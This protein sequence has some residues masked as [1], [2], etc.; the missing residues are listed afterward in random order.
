VRFIVD[1]HPVEERVEGTVALDGPGEPSPFSGWLE[2]LRLLETHVA[3][4]PVLP[5]PVARRAVR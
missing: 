3:A 2:L 4:P 5:A 1:L